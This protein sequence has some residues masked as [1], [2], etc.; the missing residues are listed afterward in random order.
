MMEKES[1]LSSALKAKTGEYEMD[2][3]EDEMELDDVDDV[4]AIVDGIKACK[5]EKK[6]VMLI[7]DAIA[8]LKAM[9]GSEE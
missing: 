6:K 5:D 2:E 1:A 9:R 7:D 8:K 4:G 3:T